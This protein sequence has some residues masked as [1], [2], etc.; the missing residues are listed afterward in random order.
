MVELV[1]TIV[2]IGILAAVVAPR[3]LSKS[4]FDSR[5]FFDRAQS[6]VRYAQKLAIAQRRTVY[7]CVSI[8]RINVSTTANDNA[9]GSLA[10]DPTGV[11]GTTGPN[12]GLL[13][14]VAPA[15]VALAPTV[16]FNFNGLGQ[17]SNAGLL[18]I[19]FSDDP[20]RHIFVEA[21]T[22]YVHP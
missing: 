18:Q 2:I 9:C 12:D 5:G 15:G 1:V 11:I 10:A 7:V 4:T 14:A 21:E 6:V 13:H 20:S 8:D 19:D 3:F 16:N 22:G 17:P